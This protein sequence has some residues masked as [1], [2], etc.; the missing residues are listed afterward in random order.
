MVIGRATFKIP[1]ISFNWI[2]TSYYGISTC[3]ITHGKY[4]KLCPFNSKQFTENV[5][6]SKS[7]VY[8]NE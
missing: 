7:V 8:H 5:Q 2:V 3:K 6:C 4:S 1:G